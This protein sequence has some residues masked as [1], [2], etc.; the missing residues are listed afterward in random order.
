MDDGDR[1]FLYVIRIIGYVKWFRKM[2]GDNIGFE[3][4]W[5]GNK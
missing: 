3:F 1:I 4:R 2:I 5:K